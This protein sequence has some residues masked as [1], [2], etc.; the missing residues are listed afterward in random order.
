VNSGPEQND[1][2]EFVLDHKAELYDLNRPL[3]GD[4]N[5]EILDFEDPLGK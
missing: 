1:D 4:C 3:E 2:P 5:L